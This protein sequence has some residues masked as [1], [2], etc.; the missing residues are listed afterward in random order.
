[1]KDL[2][3]HFKASLWALGGLFF[4]FYMI[5]TLN[6]EGGIIKAQPKKE[7]ASFSVQKVVKPKAKPKPK[8]KPKK[9]KTQPRRSAP[10]PSM[11]SGLSG[12]DMGLEGFGTEDMGDIGNSLLGDVSK[13]VIMSEDAVDVAPKPA[14]RSAMEYPKKARKNAITGY[15]VMNLLIGADGSIEKIKILESEPA[16]VFDDVAIA[17]IS[18]WL[19]TPAQYQGNPVKVWAKQKIRFDLQ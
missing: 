19:F 7:S 8:P 10:T 13:N 5:I 17:G 4:V 12:I 11:S 9:H 16:G 1:M 15:V 14:Q 6:D 2:F 18:S 3:K